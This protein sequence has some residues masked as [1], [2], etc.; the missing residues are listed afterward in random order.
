M[1]LDS[2]ANVWLRHEKSK[3]PK[4]AYTDTLQLAHGECQC[5]KETLRKGVPTVYVPGSKDGE[6]IDLFPEGF[7]WARGCSITRGDHL[8]VDTPKHR[9]LTTKLEAGRPYITKDHLELILA[10]LPKTYQT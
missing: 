2:W 9:V 5:R 10:Q 8:T 6:N 1:A 3:K 7:L 4:A